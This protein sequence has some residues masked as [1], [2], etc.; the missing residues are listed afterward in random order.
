MKIS[1]KTLHVGDCGGLNPCCVV[2]FS[3]KVRWPWGFLQVHLQHGKESSFI[4]YLRLLFNSTWG[5][6]WVFDSQRLPQCARISVRLHLYCSDRGGAPQA[7]HPSERLRWH[8]H[9]FRVQWVLLRLLSPELEGDQSV[10]WWQQSPLH[11]QRWTWLHR[12]QHPTMEQPQHSQ[13]GERP[14]LWDG[15][16]GGTER[17]ARDRHHH[18]FQRMARGDADRE[19]GAQK[20]GDPCL[21]GLSATW[22]GSLPGVDPSLGGAVQQRE[23]AVAHVSWGHIAC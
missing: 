4:L 19:G 14:L 2:L 20:D 5:L 10:L 12:H 17:E 8:V 7:W 18:V 1:Y 23:G 3:L 15:P 22:T 11:P 21:F 9:V 6:V 13:Q 16:A